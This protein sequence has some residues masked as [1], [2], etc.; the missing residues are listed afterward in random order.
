MPF[1]TGSGSVDHSTIIFGALTIVFPS[2]YSEAFRKLP[3]V[4]VEFEAFLS[5]HLTNTGDSF[6]AY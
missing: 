4:G 6:L 3:G 5:K 1:R 2:L